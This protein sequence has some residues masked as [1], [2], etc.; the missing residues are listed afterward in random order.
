[1]RRRTHPANLKRAEGSR[2][3]VRI[4][5]VSTLVMTGGGNELAANHIMPIAKA[6]F[7]ANI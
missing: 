5:I 4:E 7:G 6:I 2:R 1:M 3:Q